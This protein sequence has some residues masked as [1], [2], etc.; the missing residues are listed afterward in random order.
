MSTGLELKDFP[1]PPTEHDPKIFEWDHLIDAAAT[2]EEKKTIHELQKIHADV[3]QSTKRE[4][5]VSGVVVN[6]QK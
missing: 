6:T 1:K 5:M 4:L 3:I 2:E